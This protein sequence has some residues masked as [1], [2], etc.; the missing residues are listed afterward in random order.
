MN[1]NTYH[2]KMKTKTRLE[3]QTTPRITI[4]NNPHKAAI[5]TEMLQTSGSHKA[6]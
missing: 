1:H 4:P 3:T 5:V 2:V 6:S